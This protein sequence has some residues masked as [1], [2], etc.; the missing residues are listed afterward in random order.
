MAHVCIILDFLSWEAITLSLYW[1]YGIS[2]D[3]LNIYEPNTYCNVIF[4][5]G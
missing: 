3:E 5:F 4:S 2:E 1:F